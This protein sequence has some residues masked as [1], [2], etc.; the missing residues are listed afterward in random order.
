MIKDTVDYF[1][2]KAEN[3]CTAQT[4]LRVM[5]TMAKLCGT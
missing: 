3:P 1:L 4:G 5:E 2:G